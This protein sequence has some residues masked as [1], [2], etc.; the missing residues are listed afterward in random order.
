MMQ[1]GAELRDQNQALA[2]S[3]PAQT[4]TYA[5]STASY[6]PSAPA[7][8]WPPPYVDPTYY[9]S[10][11]SAPSS[12]VYIGENYGYSSLGYG[13]PYSYYPYRNYYSSYYPRVGFSGPR[14]NFNFGAPFGGFRVGGFGGG[15]HGGGFGGGFHGGGGMHGGG[16]FH[17]GRR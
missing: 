12:V 3:A 1:R 2:A 7:Q 16:G 17:G 15:F 14:F 10:Y 9:S 5:Q 4:Q 13:Y 8:S 6:A 11:Y